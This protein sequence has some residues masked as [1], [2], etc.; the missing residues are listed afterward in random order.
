MAIIDV[1]DLRYVLPGSRVLFEA[2]SFRIGDGQHASLVGANGAGKTTLLKL[3]AGR[4]ERHGG[5]IHV[6]GALG[7]MQQFVA[8]AP[9]A[10]TI[11]SFLLGYAAGPALSPAESRS[12]SR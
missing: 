1:S 9:E 11:R 6:D 12:G 10:S 8:A 7:F 3:I 4:L 5:H 2:V